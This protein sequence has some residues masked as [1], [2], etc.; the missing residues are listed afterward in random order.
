MNLKGAADFLERDWSL[1]A[2]EKERFWA[3]ALASADPAEAFRIAEELRQ[4]ALL[5][6]P[7]WPSAEDRLQDLRAHEALAELMTRATPS[8]A[9]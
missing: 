3:R 1:L 5:L 6:H 4:E 7:D 2:A 8:R 9:G